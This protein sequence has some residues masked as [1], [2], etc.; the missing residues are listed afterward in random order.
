[1]VGL[2]ST[3]AEASLNRE[4]L[5]SD[6]IMR[7]SKNAQ[8]PLKVRL[9]VPFEWNLH[10]EKVTKR[11]SDFGRIANSSTEASLHREGPKSDL[12]MRA[13]KNAQIP[14]KLGLQAPF[15]LNF[16]LEKVTKIFSDF[17]RIA[18]HQ[19]VSLAS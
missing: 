12:T 7:A 18:K 9:L 6:L 14:L 2:P 13:S 19:C 16:H 4:W 17:G 10:L 15:E 8:I 5:K 3:G 1:M 11:F